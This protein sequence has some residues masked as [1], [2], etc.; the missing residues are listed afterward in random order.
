MRRSRSRSSKTAKRIKLKPAIA[1]S[2]MA[3]ARTA[4][5]D[6]S[7]SAPAPSAKAGLRSSKERSNMML[8]PRPRRMARSSIQAAPLSSR[9]AGRNSNSAPSAITS[10]AAAAAVTVTPVRPANR[11]RRPFAATAAPKKSSAA[12]DPDSPF[13]AL[14]RLKEQMEKQKQDET[15]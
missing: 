12:I 13:A 5:A 1:S 14:S 7:I 9:R 10:R 3:A 6:G 4:T 11:T 2:G 8:A 15:V